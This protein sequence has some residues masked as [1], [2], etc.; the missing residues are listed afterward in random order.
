MFQRGLALVSAPCSCQANDVARRRCWD[1][2]TAITI[3]DNLN[4]GSVD[5]CRDGHIG[6]QKPYCHCERLSLIV[7]YPCASELTVIPLLVNSEIS[8]GFQS[9]DASACPCRRQGWQ[10]MHIAIIALQ[11]HFG[12]A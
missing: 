10:Q 8:Y 5:S 7:Y 4:L 9:L 6:R 12:H 1:R 3:V 2:E 11:Q